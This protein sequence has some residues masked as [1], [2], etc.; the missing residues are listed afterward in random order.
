MSYRLLA[1]AFIAVFCLFVAANYIIWTCWTE[2][3]LTDRNGVGGDLART[4]Y[5]AGIKHPRQTYVDLPR[6]HIEFQDYQ[7]QPVDVLTIGDSF[8]NGGGGGRNNFYQDYIASLNGMTVLNLGI[9]DQKQG[10][11]ST[12]VTL[13]NSG[14]LDIIKPKAVVLQSAERLSIERFGQKIVFEDALDLKEIKQHYQEHRESPNYMPSISFIN[15]GN[16][17]FLYYSLLYRFRD[18]ANGKVIVRKLS[19]PFFST[20]LDSTL[21]FWH[22]DLRNL[23]QQTPETTALLNDNLNK[24]A[25]LLVRKGIRLYFMPSVDKYNLYRGYI[26]ANP[27]P[28]NT[29]FEELRPLPKNYTFIDT[30]AI[31]SEALQ[32]GEKDVYYADDTH[33]SWKAPELIFSKVRF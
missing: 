10:P 25:T 32:R 22:D 28:E 11:L 16:F 30:K 18:S 19:K 27:Y 23:S 21:I 2:R 8:S 26:V 9:L 14:Y 13:Y 33:W 4:G 1:R 20:K 12:L 5:I 15:T 7:D 17:K 24:M 31:L 3:L 6:R 29:F